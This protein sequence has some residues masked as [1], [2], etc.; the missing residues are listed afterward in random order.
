MHIGEPFR[1][2][3]GILSGVHTFASADDDEGDESMLDR[4][5]ARDSE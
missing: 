4:P 1:R 5:Y 3:S 2:V